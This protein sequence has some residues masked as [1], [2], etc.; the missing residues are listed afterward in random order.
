MVSMTDDTALIPTH[1]PK[2]TRAPAAT[3]ESGTIREGIT[4]VEA[5]LGKHI[6]C[7]RFSCTTFSVFF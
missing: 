1:I 3:G 2:L 6:R 4:A 7:I 5:R